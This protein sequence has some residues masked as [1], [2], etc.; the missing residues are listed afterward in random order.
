MTYK[1]LPNYLRR[2]RKRAGLSQDEVAFLL[3]GR[4]GAKISQYERFRRR[5]T[6]ETAFAFEAAFGVPAHTLFAGVSE[7][8]RQDVA[9]RKDALI[10]RIEGQSGNSRKVEHLR[11]VGLDP[12]RD[13]RH[14]PELDR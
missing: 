12:K 13:P 6:L 8:I 11:A 2:H 1:P 10:R 5:P 9:K 3:G 4:S 14:Q 7:M